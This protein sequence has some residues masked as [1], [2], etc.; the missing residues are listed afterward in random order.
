MSG[1]AVAPAAIDEGRARLLGRMRGASLGAMVMLIIQYALGMGVNIYVT[2]GKGGFSEAFK[3]GPAL[4]LHAILGL[5]LIVAAIGLLVRAI[6]ARHGAVIAASA[7][8]LVAIAG[9]A[10]SGVS[11]L[12]DGADGSSMA[13][14]MATAVALLCYTICLYVLG[15]PARRG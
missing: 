13:M 6:T 12:K 9:A 5:L 10:M 7:V 1:T 2:P 15:S 8:G 3:S 11:F 4:A 14:A